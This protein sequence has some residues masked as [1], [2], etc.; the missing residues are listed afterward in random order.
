MSILEPYLAVYFPHA[1]SLLARAY[2]EPKIWFEVQS[3]ISPHPA[4]DHSC[5]PTY[6]DFNPLDSLICFDRILQ[7]FGPFHCLLLPSHE[8][9]PSALSILYE[10]VPSPGDSLSFETM[11]ATDKPRHQRLR[12]S[13]DGCF[14]AKVKCSKTQ[15]ICNRCLTSGIDCHYSPSSRIGKP[16]STGG[17]KGESSATGHRAEQSPMPNGQS[18]YYQTPDSAAWASYALASGAG[19][20]TQSPDINNVMTRSH[21]STPG[22]GFNGAVAEGSG[23]AGPG[24]GVGGMYPAATGW[25]SPMA[26]AA[27]QFS[28]SAGMPGQLQQDDSQPATNHPLDIQL[29]RAWS[30]MARQGQFAQDADQFLTPE[31]MAEYYPGTTPATPDPQPGQRPPAMQRH[32]ASL[33]GGTSLEN[34]VPGCICHT[35]PVHSPY[36]VHDSNFRPPPGFRPQ[37]GDM[38]AQSQQPPNRNP[39]TY[40]RGT[41]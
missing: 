21:S 34:L 15:P 13:C 14:T 2:T 6:P 16:K 37:D 23:D 25:A 17:T 22:L 8:Y 31:S 32:R 7:Y 39:R 11:S 24:M 3:Y 19:W 38:A 1:S 33:P 36:L 20:A 18:H 29:W 27:A 35:C 30:E 5:P 26:P 9:A 12:Q 4:S 40:Q 41:F 10:L 28:G